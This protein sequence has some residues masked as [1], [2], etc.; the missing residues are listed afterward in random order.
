MSSLS[1]GLDRLFMPRSVAMRTR[2]PA[3]RTHSAVPRLM[4]RR[5]VDSKSGIG[6]KDRVLIDGLTQMQPG[7][8]VNAKLVKITPRTQDV[9]PQSAPLV[10]PPPSEATTR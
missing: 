9:G 6:P 5:S 8:A 10:T 2:P 7:V 1:A 4:F 3:S